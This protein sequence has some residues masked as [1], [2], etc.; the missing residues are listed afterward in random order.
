MKKEENSAQR[1]ESARRIWAEIRAE[2]E[3]PCTNQLIQIQ[4]GENRSSHHS[5]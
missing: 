1:R 2:R 4:G 3:V 5:N